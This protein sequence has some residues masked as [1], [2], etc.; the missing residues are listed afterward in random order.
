MERG[1]QRSIDPQKEEGR[2]KQ[3][4]LE[5]GSQCKGQG[6]PCLQ[7]QLVTCP[8]KPPFQEGVQ[9]SFYTDCYLLPPHVRAICKGR[10]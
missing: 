8:G 3:T 6:W 9:A 2:R 7:A 1:I 5:G 10:G 4:H